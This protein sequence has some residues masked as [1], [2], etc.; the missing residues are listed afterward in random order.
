MSNYVS[1]PENID[2]LRVRLANL[3]A[4]LLEGDYEFESTVILTN[5]LREYTA[6]LCD[7]EEKTLFT[8]LAC[9]FIIEYI[10]DVCPKYTPVTSSSPLPVDD[11]VTETV[12]PL[13]VDDTVTETVSPLPVDDTETE[14]VSPLPVDDTETETVSPLPVDDTVVELLS[15]AALTK[16]KEYAMSPVNTTHDSSVTSSDFRNIPLPPEIDACDQNDDSPDDTPTSP[17]PSMVNWKQDE[18]SASSCILYSPSMFVNIASNVPQVN[19]IP[20]TPIPLLNRELSDNVNESEL[21]PDDIDIVVSQTGASRVIAAQ[22]LRKNKN[23]VDAIL[24]LTP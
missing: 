15:D 17:S 4:H 19:R 2:N 3:S 14:T 10:T 21:D 13:P 23:I 24:D 16:L 9:K 6:L 11:T 18:P 7:K 22:S 1:I 8:T 12:S 20:T 5:L